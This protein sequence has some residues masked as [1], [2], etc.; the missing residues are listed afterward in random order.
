M[1]K[2]AVTILFLFFLTSGLLSAQSLGPLSGKNLYLPHLAVFSFPGSQPLKNQKG[3]EW[4]SQLY[5]V[6]EFF[7]WGVPD[8]GAEALATVSN[9]DQYLHLDYESL[10]W[11]ES[12]IFNGDFGRLTLTLRLFSYF[13]GI[14]DPLIEGFHDFLNVPNAGRE[15]F[16]QNRLYIDLYGTSGP[17]PSLFAAWAGLGDT[18]LQFQRTLGAW[19]AWDFSWTAALSLPTG[20][21]GLSGSGYPDSGVLLSG[22]YSGN[23]NFFHI[24]SGMVLPGE[25][26]LQK[27]S[28]LQPSW[29]N[30]L[31]WEFAWQENL[32]LL[33]QVHLNTSPINS[34]YARRVL[35][36]DAY[37]YQVLQTN[38][39]LGLKW[40][41]DKGML[42]FY[43]EEDPFTHE[44][45]DILLNLGFCRIW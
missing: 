44:G 12:L 18:D 14:G 33:A 17:D 37:A 38:L 36:W 22:L 31:G 5:W 7:L 42:Q 24:Q 39:K 6:N 30:L 35:L 41:M 43:A 34:S 25:L 32:S 26:L 29:Q 8:E 10:V 23:R 40:R 45:A 20:I 28:G 27:D 9:P 2:P 13:P 4:N 19:G 11:E 21:R 3:W 16:P 1:R 15:Y